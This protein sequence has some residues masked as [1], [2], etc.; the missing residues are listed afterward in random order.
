[1]AKK[2]F[3]KAPKKAEVLAKQ[4]ADIDV[5]T[6]EMLQLAT[7]WRWHY[8]NVVGLGFFSTAGGR[9]VVIQWDEGGSSRKQGGVSDEEW[10]VFKL[11]FE[12]TGRIA[13]ISDK[14]DPQWKF[15]YRFLEA[16]R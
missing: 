2:K 11:A 10:E 16:Q 5:R 4:R 1:M 6:L 14:A 7:A 9:E 8:G 13:V 12:G 15:D 3:E